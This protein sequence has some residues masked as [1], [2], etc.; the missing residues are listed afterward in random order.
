M[1]LRETMNNNPAVVTGGAVVILLLCLFLVYWQFSGGS[2]SS[3][4]TAQLIYYDVAND[5]LKLMEWDSG[6]YPDS[7]PPG[8]TDVY[9]AV[10]LSCGECPEGPDGIVDGMTPEQIKA[11][12]MFVGWLY[13]RA[14]GT[15]PD[16]MVNESM[17]ARPLKGSTWIKVASKQWVDLEEKL[18]RQ[19]P[20]GDYA[21]ECY[22]PTK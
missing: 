5:K 15:E 1:G 20:R 4:V 12:G 3:N 21:Y 14:P 10:L 17:E 6:P 8:M 22:P 18:R 9:E 7:P 16:P 2:G 19:C 11:A 13:R